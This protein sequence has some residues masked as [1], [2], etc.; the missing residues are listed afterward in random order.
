MSIQKLC[1]KQKDDRP[2]WSS[3]EEDC[4]CVCCDGVSTASASVTIRVESAVTD[5]RDLPYWTAR[6][7]IWKCRN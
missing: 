1:V 3:L 6:H 2:G 4:L 7:P 5:E